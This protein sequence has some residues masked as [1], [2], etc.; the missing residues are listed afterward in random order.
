MASRPIYYDTETTGIKADQD[1]V[2][3]IAA[4]DPENDLY[5]EELVNPG[6]PIPEE[7]SKVHHIDDEMVKDK[8]S[9]QQVGQRFIDFCSGD[10]ILI[11]H[12][13]DNFDIH[14]LR[15][16][17]QRNGLNMPQEWRFLDSLKW[18]RKYRSDLPRHSLQYLREVFEFP[19]N[20]A[21]RALDDVVM[22]HQIF[23][24]MI[25]DLPI[26]KV[27]ELCYLK[28]KLTMPF[29]K[30]KGKALDQIP[31]DYVLWLKDSQAF[32]KVENQEL[33]QAFDKMGYFHKETLL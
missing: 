8:D 19:K 26:D 11:A 27:H 24:E 18:A 7:A 21:H 14:F 20:N 25:D 6:C 4:Y 17:F 32:D 5:F 9:F 12:N 10:V 29:G 15:H 16:E 2:V 31:K 13:N 1:R 30:Y 33:F 22:L 28:A 23:Q 3:E